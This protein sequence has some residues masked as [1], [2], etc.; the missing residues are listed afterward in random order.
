MTGYCI[1]DKYCNYKS[2]T[3]Y[4]GYTGGCVL[5]NTATV[6]IP[7]KQSCHISQVVDISPDSIEAIADAVVRK[8]RG[9]EE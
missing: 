4:C 2:D 5:E 8:L 1:T 6:I 3:G 7:N 9:E